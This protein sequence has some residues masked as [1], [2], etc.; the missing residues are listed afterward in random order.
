MTVMSTL[1]KSTDAAQNM[2]LICR[3]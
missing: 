1:L 2:Y 3:I